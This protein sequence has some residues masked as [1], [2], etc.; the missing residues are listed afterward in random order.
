MDQVL[1]V[2]LGGL[3]YD[4]INKAVVEVAPVVDDDDD[5]VFACVVL[6]DGLDPME[7]AEEVDDSAPLIVDMEGV[8][9][10]PPQELLVQDELLEGVCS[11]FGDFIPQALDAVRHEVLD[12]EG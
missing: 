5:I 1:L 8:L 11:R 12:A 9:S 7:V 2:E 10:N 6:L 3:G 4:S